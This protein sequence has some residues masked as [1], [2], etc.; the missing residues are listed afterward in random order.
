M[1][2][3]KSTHIGCYIKV[4]C[5]DIVEETISKIHPITKKKFNNNINF[6]PETGVKLI[7]VIKTKKEKSYFSFYNVEEVLENLGIREDTFFR[8]PYPEYKDFNVFILNSYTEDIFKYSDD[9][10][11]LLELGSV[12]GES[13]VAKF[14]KK[15]SKVLEYFEQNGWEYFVGFGVFN[16]AV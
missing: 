15:Y 6:C 10:G 16:Y 11:F 2:Y 1:G 7:P 13:E 9:G 12:D 14:K 4:F 3:S 5:K 8:P